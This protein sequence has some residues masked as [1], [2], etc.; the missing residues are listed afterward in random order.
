MDNPTEF[1]FGVNWS[2]RYW[3][4]IFESS[5][6]HGLTILTYEADRL[7][8]MHKHRHSKQ[9]IWTLPTISVLRATRPVLYPSGVRNSTFFW[10]GWGCILIDEI[11]KV[12]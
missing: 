8:Y 2:L 7:K 3:P 4:G 12:I 10:E 11:C 9:I 1:M 6:S 5:N